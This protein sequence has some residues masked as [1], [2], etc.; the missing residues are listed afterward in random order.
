MQLASKWGPEAKVF[1]GACW[2]PFHPTSPL[3]PAVGPARGA[4]QLLLRIRRL[5]S[6]RASERNHTQ[7]KVK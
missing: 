2:E 5:D 1:H 6:P 3:L 4:R 7:S